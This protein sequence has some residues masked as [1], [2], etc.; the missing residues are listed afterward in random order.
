MGYMYERIFGWMTDMNGVRCEVI[1]M[2]KKINDVKELV[3]YW[4]GGY[5]VVV[6]NLDAEVIEDIKYDLDELR[7][8]VTVYDDGSATVVSY[9]P[10]TEQELYRLFEVVNKHGYIIQL[11]S[12]L[13]D[14]RVKFVL[15][16]ADI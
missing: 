12:G 16:K 7:F 1:R 11:A 2:G 15:R 8:D 6:N 10:I 9:G 13:S 4:T 14:G 5:H 3:R